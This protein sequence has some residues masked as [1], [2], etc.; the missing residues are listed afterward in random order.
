MVLNQGLKCN[1]KT[2]Q[3]NLKNLATV[4]MVFINKLL[5]RS[6]SLPSKETYALVAQSCPILC[7][8][9]DYSP[10]GSSVHGI[11]QARTLEWVAICFSRE[12][13]WRRDWTWV[14][15][16]VGIFFIVRATKEKNIL[17]PLLSARLCIR[18]CAKSYTQISCLF[19]S[20]SYIHHVCMLYLFF[21]AKFYISTCQQ[22]TNFKNKDYSCLK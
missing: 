13:S 5:R 18:H 20:Y 1:S 14:S 7:D 3:R 17:V 16:V 11:L 12:S 19:V 22:N 4:E 15:C 6:N 2:I 8:F 10:P 9:M 21:L